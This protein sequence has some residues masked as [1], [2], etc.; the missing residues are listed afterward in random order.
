MTAAEELNAVCFAACLGEQV[1]ASLCTVS[2]KIGAG[3]IAFK[4]LSLELVTIFLSN[5]LTRYWWK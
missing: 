5:A 2:V 3:F 1:R 4:L